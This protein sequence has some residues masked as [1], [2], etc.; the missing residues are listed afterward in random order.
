MYHHHVVDVSIIIIDVCVCVLGVCS[1]LNCSILR[2]PLY[3]RLF[4]MRTLNEL[5]DDNEVKMNL[6]CNITA[7]AATHNFKC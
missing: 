1:C 4:N 5:T 7:A 6:R 3:I 2:S